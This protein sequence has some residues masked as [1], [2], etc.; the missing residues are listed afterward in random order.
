LQFLTDIERNELKGLNHP[1]VDRMVEALDR[2]CEDPRTN[3][4][5]SIVDFSNKVAKELKDLTTEETVLLKSSDDKFF[6]RGIALIKSFSD[7]QK[8]LDSG[9]K[10]LEKES[11]PSD[12]NQ[13]S[14]NLL[15]KESKKWKKSQK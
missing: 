8:A 10:I 9:F 7:L 13:G 6:E 12:E 15:E 11:L 4:H 5:Q 2:L 3:L 14:T 1:V